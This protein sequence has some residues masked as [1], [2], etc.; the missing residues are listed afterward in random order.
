M[1]VVLERKIE[2][3]SIWLAKMKMDD[4]C[5]DSIRHVT[6]IAIDLQDGSRAIVEK[7]RFNQFSQVGNVHLEPG[8]MQSLKWFIEAVEKR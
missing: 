1:Y 4:E 3:G 5:K 7:D 6:R 2:K 8:L